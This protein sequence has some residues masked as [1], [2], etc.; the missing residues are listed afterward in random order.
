MFGVAPGPAFGGAVLGQVRLR[1]LSLGA[2]LRVMSSPFA[3]VD[4]DA[5][6]STTFVGG[7][8]SGCGHAG[9]GSLCWLA[10]VGPFWARSAGIANPGS[11]SGLFA[12]SGA[13]LA[14]TLPLSGEWA[15]TGNVEAL[16]PLFRPSVEIDGDEVWRVSSVT[17]GGA[18]GAL[19]HF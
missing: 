19:V 13:R 3:D 8:I 6:V 1:A 7:E 4:G 18:L 11:D 2:G 14:V 9:V 5:R 16:L 12:A 10:V 17:A 15:V